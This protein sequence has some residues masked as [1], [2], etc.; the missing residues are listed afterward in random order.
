[1]AKEI[2]TYCMRHPSVADTAEGFARWRFMEEAVRG[3]TE[4]AAAALEWL[5][6]EGYLRRVPALGSDPLFTLNR[7]RVVEVAEFLGES[8]EEG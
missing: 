5:E 8:R 7:A 3:T 4:E 1:M 2:L 6:A